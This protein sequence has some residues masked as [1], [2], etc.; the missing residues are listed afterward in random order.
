MVC[1]E[2]PRCAWEAAR[3]QQLRAKCPSVVTLRKSRHWP[4]SWLVSPRPS[5]AESATPLYD[6]WAGA[7]IGAMYPALR[8]L[9]QP[10]KAATR[11]AGFGSLVCARVNSYPPGDVRVWPCWWG[12]SVAHD[13]FRNRPRESREAAFLASFPPRPRKPA[14]DFSPQCQ[15][16]SFNLKVI[17]FFGSKKQHIPR[18]S[19]QKFCIM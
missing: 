14:Q 10:G 16:H 18:R 19:C 4:A 13:F 5:P 7:G 17:M 2:D 1:A 8:D 12:S 15:K 9:P 11:S 3:A 6:P